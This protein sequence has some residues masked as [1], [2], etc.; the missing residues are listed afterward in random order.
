MIDQKHYVDE[1]VIF[2]SLDRSSNLECLNRGLPLDDTY[3]SFTSV[4]GKGN[5]NSR[6]TAIVT[7]A[8]TLSSAMAESLSAAGVSSLGAVSLVSCFFF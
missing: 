6:T 4:L 8:S 3:K 7:T 5:P 2:S 1:K